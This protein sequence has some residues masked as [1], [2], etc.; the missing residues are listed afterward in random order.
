MARIAPTAVVI[1]AVALG[2]IGVVAGPMRPSRES[3]GP[4]VHKGVFNPDGTPVRQPVPIGQTIEHVIFYNPPTSGSSGPISITD[5][6]SPNQTYVPGSIVAPPGWTW[7]NPPYGSGNTTTYSHPGY[8]P[9]TSFIVNVPVS[10]AS[11]SS[12]VGGDGFAPIPIGNNIMATY[13]HAMAGW[14]KI[15]CWDAA[16]FASCPGVWPRSLGNDIGTP[17]E[18][19]HVI[20]GTRIYYP[21][22]ST[23]GG[24]S[25]AGIGCWETQ[26]EAPCAVPF[27]GFGAMLGANVSGSALDQ[28]IGGVVGNKAVNPTRLYLEADG[29]VYCWDLGTAAPCGGWTSPA[30]ATGGSSYHGLLLEDAAA[31]TRL[32]VLHGGSSGGSVSCLDL[33]SGALCAPNWF[34]KPLSGSFTALTPYLNTTGT[35]TTDVCAVGFSA[36]VSC[37]DT[38][39]GNVSSPRPAAFTS[40]FGSL[41]FWSSLRIPGTKRVLYAGWQTPRCWDFSLVAPCT[42]ADF[43]TGWNPL[44]YYDYAYRP[45]PASPKS[46]LFGLG[47]MGM[48]FRFTA[49]GGF[50]ANGCAAHFETDFDFDA[51]A[52]QYF[53]GKKPGTLTWRS[54]AILGRPAELTGGTLRLLD[55]NGLTVQT[56]PV[57]GANAYALNIPASGATRTVTLQFD[58]VYSSTPANG[59]QLEIG[60][61]ADVLPQICYQATVD[62]CG[63]VTNTADMRGRLLGSR[64]P[65]DQTSLR[66]PVC[67]GTY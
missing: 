67:R 25:Q 22:S 52:A 44:T 38:A 40:L 21:A 20:A 10:G 34:N 8:G 7:T 32:F 45:D 23:V 39:S 16:T 56:I 61:D 11:A 48:P 30:L 51:V 53:C 9:G 43:T 55:M 66:G 57:T 13:H 59:Y 54:I 27:L 35:A 42:A 4:G 3:P 33:S 64:V 28:R 65:H 41:S 2:C 5:T 29:T 63:P 18:N 6:L 62:R 60:F 14:A 15:M 37:V 26:T 47:H 58:P 12:S 31:P 36:G 1:A 17:S 19:N 50:G 24:N 49:K 46:C